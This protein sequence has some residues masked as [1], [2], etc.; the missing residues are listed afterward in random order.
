MEVFLLVAP[1]QETEAFLAKVPR[2]HFLYH[3]FAGSYSLG[4]L[5]CDGNR[6]VWNIWGNAENKTRA[7]QLAQ[8]IQAEQGPLEVLVWDEPLPEVLVWHEPLPCDLTAEEV[9]R[10]R[11]AQQQNGSSH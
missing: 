3:M 7:L 9:E 2:D 10:I 8:R 5:V 11:R 1:S 4:W 6:C